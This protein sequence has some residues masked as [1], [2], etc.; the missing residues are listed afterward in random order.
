MGTPAIHSDEY[1]SSHPDWRG[2]YQQ[3][4]N[5]LEEQ[6]VADRDSGA[7]VQLVDGTWERASGMTRS[8]LR[9]LAERR[10]RKILEQ[11]INENKD[12]ISIGKGMGA[13]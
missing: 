3:L 13:L 1:E 10:G 12:V 2:S 4:V 11:A 8:E 7:R 6:L 9:E 5:E